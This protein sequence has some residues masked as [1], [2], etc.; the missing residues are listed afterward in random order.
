MQEDGCN[1]EPNKHTFEESR[2]SRKREECTREQARGGSEREVRLPPDDEG[3]T[4]TTAEAEHGAYPKSVQH[5][6]ARTT[7]AAIFLERAACR[8]AQ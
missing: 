6:R 4:R 5:H 1:A 7:L 8:L 2:V 3:A